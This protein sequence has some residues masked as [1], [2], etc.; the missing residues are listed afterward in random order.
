M[1]HHSAGAVQVRADLSSV[2]A[3]P[4]GLEV[5]ERLAAEWRELCLN[6][7]SDQP[8]YRPEWI[9][10][11]VQSYDPAAKLHV[12]SVTA[13][14]R[15]AAVLPL[16]H[17]H[18]FCGFP[19]RK[20]RGATTWDC[21]RFD[22]VRR[23][24]APGERA[25][26]EIW[27]HLSERRDWDVLELP[28]VPCGGGA[29]T[30]YSA[31]QAAGYPVARW[32]SIRSPIVSITPNGA[33]EASGRF[34]KHLRGYVR[35]LTAQGGSLALR[36]VQAADPDALAEFYSLERSGWKGRSQSA[37]LDKP[38]SQEF[39]DRIARDAAQFGY[40][41]LYFLD[42][43]GKAIAGHLGLSYAGR[44]FSPKVA[45]DEQFRDYAPGH[46]IINAIVQ[47]C[48]QRGLSEYDI[49]G[50]S[51]DWKARWTSRTLPHAR[52][53]IFQDSAYGRMLH[54][55]RFRLAPVLKRLLKK[56]HAASPPAAQAEEPGQR[57]PQ[58]N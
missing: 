17:E 21:M 1:A 30:L 26:N 51:D 9:A 36:H 28:D 3:E 13:G 27:R 55:A 42:F 7:P 34:R 52:L 25:V 5:V 53:F 44:Y 41:S 18:L 29:E 14:G 22:L 54:A 11:Y 35:K 16:V 38:K 12:I 40:L 37:I 48:V 58:E 31:A 23:G 46:L 15:L 47:D 49:C 39:Y 10:A 33:T 50:D 57:E 20:L 6:A 43:N 2:N 4:G 45:F 32:D 24:G 56:H 19:A 8:F